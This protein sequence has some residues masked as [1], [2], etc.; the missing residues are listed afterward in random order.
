[1]TQPVKMGIMKI[2]FQLSVVV[3]IIK[4][5]AIEMGAQDLMIF[6]KSNDTKI[7]QLISQMTVE[8]K[9]Y[10]LCSFY[11]GRDQNILTLMFV[12][13]FPIWL[14]ENVCMV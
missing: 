4:S 7:Q 3:L 1:M 8:E 2:I 10:Q 9:A 11:Y 14:P 13:V 5:F 6:S 12:S